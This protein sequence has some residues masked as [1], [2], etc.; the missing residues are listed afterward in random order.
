MMYPELAWAGAGG[1][2]AK[3]LSKSIWVRIGLAILA[4]IFLP[5]IIMGYIRER[6]KVKQT[7]A[8]LALLS[9]KHQAFNFLALKPRITNVYTRVQAA[10]DK[11][12][13]DEA[14]EW[15]DDWYWQNQKYVYLDRW[16]SQGLKNIVNVK[17]VKKIKPL[18]V[19]YSGEPNAEDSRLVVEITAEMQD[20]L[21]NMET[22][23]VV[24]GDREF[25]DVENIWTFVYRNGRWVVENIEEATEFSTYLRLENV[26]QTARA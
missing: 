6:R 22:K 11:G 2:I 3:A 19:A 15:M 10:W 5:L 4:V 12:M 9:K 18:H 23:M 25:K 7:T 8:D 1:K 20:Y 14:S 17:K 26:V 21:V 24:E 16:E 13:I